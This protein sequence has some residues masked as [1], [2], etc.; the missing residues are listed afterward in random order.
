MIILGIDPGTRRVGYGVLEKIGGT[1]SLLETGI[2][3]IKSANDT[4]AL[5]ETKKGM[6][7]L[8]KKFKPDVVGIEK[9]FFS[10]NRKTG[11]AVAQA[12]GVIILS[13]MENSVPIREYSPNAIKLS[14]TGHGGADK[15]AVYKMVCLSLKNVPNNLLDDASDA[16]AL[17]IVAGNEYE[18]EKRF[19]GS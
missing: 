15:K 8:I 11:I 1:F 12:R 17:A 2:L 6:D 5:E 3:E 14:L 18:R 10:K 16:L 4:S 7:S 9:I 19:S 13:A